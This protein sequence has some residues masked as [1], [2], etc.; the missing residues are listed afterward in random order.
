MARRAF[1]VFPARAGQREESPSQKPRHCQNPRTQ[2]RRIPQSK[3]ALSAAPRRKSSLPS[4]FQEQ[5]SGRRA[6]AKSP[7]TAKNR[8]HKPAVSRKVKA[9]QA[10]PRDITVLCLLSRT[11]QREES[12]SQKP[13]HCQKPRTQIRRIPQGKG[14]LSAVPR[15]KSSLPFSG[16]NKPTEG[17]S[18]QKTPTPPKNADTNPVYPAK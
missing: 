9:R 7:G 5:A 13:R 18:E 1:F 8:G 12:P 15:R 2:I 6:R 16:K 3:G 11:S 17:E 14:A 4:F 10:P